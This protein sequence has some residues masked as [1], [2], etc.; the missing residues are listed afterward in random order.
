MIQKWQPDLQFQLD[1]LAP[2]FPRHQLLVL[3]HL[4]TAFQLPIPIQ[5]KLKVKI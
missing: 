5:L 2:P 1:T 4:L 3:V